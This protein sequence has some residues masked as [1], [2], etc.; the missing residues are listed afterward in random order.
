[1]LSVVWQERHPDCKKTEWW[2]AAMVICLGRCA[3]WH[4]A[5]LLP[6]PLT[7]SCSSKYR[8]VLAF[9]YRLTQF[10]LDKGPLSVCVLLLLVIP[11]PTRSSGRRYSV[12]LLK[13]LSFFFS[14]FSFAKGSLRWLYRQ[15]T[16]IAQKI[17]YMC[18][19]IKLV[20]NLVADPPLKFGGLKTSNF[21]QFSDDLRLR[22]S[23]APERKKISPI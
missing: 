6:L 5:Q 17:G 8:L 13:F 22:R 1:M 9:W 3:D 23:T 11:P 10:V 18:N 14:F 16:F 2:V 21:G 4:I 20:Q 19:F 12:L 7:V 15:G